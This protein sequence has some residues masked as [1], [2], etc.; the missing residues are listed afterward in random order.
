MRIS[1]VSSASTN[2]HE[3]SMRRPLTKLNVNCPAA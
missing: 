1:L 2:R 3:L